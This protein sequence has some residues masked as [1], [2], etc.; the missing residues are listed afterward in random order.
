MERPDPYDRLAGV[1]N[2]YLSGFGLRVLP[3]LTRLALCRLPMGA[4]VLDLCCGTGQ[5]AELLSQQSFR[6]TGLDNSAGMLEFAR[7]NAPTAKFVLADAR[8]FSLPCLFDAAVSVHD[9]INH[10]L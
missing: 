7:A 9:S 8:D 3:V 5:L 6:V 4:G 2:R 1:Y 10:F